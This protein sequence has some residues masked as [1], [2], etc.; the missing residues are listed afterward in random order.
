MSIYFQRPLAFVLLSLIFVQYPAYAN[1]SLVWH[2][3]TQSGVSGVAIT[4]TSKDTANSLASLNRDVKTGKDTSGA[5]KNNLDVNEIQTGFAVTQA[6]VQQANTFVAIQAQKAE[7]AK[8]ALKAEQAKPTNQ[9]A[10][11]KITSLT[12]AVDNGAKW[13]AGGTYRQIATALTAASGSAQ[14]AVTPFQS[15]AAQS[16]PI[17]NSRLKPI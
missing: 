4:L 9:Q 3:T 11:T 7:Q 13:D 17:T 16:S 10:P 2:R 12:Q 5:L 14:I 6:F 1:S 15:Q 8:T